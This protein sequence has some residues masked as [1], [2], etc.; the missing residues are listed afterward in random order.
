[1]SA[2]IS[3]VVLFQAAEIRLEERVIEELNQRLVKINSKLIGG[4]NQCSYQRFVFYFYLQNKFL[5]FHHILHYNCC[6]NSEFSF[7]IYYLDF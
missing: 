2:F 5:E 7:Q 6:P 4:Q 1:M 3:A